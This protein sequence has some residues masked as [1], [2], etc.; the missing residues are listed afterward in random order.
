VIVDFGYLRSLRG[1]VV[2]VG[3]GFDPL[4]QGHIAY[5][6][7]ATQ[8]NLPVL[9]SIDGDHYVATKHRPLLNE[10]NRAQVID[11]VRYIDYTLINLGTSADVLKELRPARLVKGIDWK[12]RLPEK[13]I[14]ICAAH[15]IEISYVDTVIDSSSQL[16]STFLK[17]VPQ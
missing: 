6:K 12:G 14:E 13:E 5:F 11:A 9:C 10:H 1:K 16:L 4:H 17:E 2:M 15:G 8:F 7:A 3:G